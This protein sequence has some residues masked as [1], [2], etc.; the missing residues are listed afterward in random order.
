M[1]HEKFYGSQEHFWGWKCI[2]CGEILD[3]MILENRSGFRALAILRG[4]SRRKSR[5]DGGGITDG[6]QGRD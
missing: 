4:G 1:I 6:N 5:A 3:Q 2:F